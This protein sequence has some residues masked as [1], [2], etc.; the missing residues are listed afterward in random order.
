MIC[1]EC[2][3]EYREGIYRCPECEVELSSAAQYEA[4][5][6]TPP[7]D[8]T[9]AVTVFE[10]S[11]LGSIEL[12]RALLRDAGIGCAVRNERTLGLLPA[13]FGGGER[14]RRAELQVTQR[15]ERRAREVLGPLLEER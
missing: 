7:R 2:A 6:P 15:N 5:H 3:A 13:P 9:P 12:A 8:D 10:S 14:L 4:L 11:D 1:P